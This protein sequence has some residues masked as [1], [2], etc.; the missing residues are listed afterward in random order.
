MMDS[1]DSVAPSLAS[2]DSEDV[3][4]VPAARGW[5]CGHALV[6]LWFAGLATF[7]ASLLLALFLWSRWHLVV[8]VLLAAT[9]SA[10][11]VF[12]MAYLAYVSCTRGHLEYESV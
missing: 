6:A 12:S 1:E 2:E 7:L 8:A 3:V 9:T 4:S 11:V 5:P 10:L